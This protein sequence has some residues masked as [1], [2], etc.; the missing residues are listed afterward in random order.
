MDMN[1]DNPTDFSG[2]GNSIAD[3]IHTGVADLQK[4]ANVGEGAVEGVGKAASATVSGAGHL[5]G[6]AVSG[7]AHLAGGATEVAGHATGGLLSGLGHATSWIGGHLGDNS[8]AHAISGAGSSMA[9]SGQSIKQSSD[10]A[11]ANMAAAG[12]KTGANISG[13]A[14]ATAGAIKG[15]AD[16]VALAIQGAVDKLGGVEK[17]WRGR[18]HTAKTLYQWLYAHGPLD[19]LQAALRPIPK[20]GP[21]A[22]NGVHS[23]QQEMHRMINGMLGTAWNATLDAG[24]NALNKVIG[25]VREKTNIQTKKTPAGGKGPI[26]KIEQFAANKFGNVSDLYDQSTGMPKVN[27]ETGT[28]NGIAPGSYTPPSHTEVA[29]D[30]G[31]IENTGAKDVTKGEADAKEEQGNWLS[32]I[33]QQIALYATE[34]VGVPVEACWNVVDGG[35]TISEKDPRLDAIDAK[36]NEFFAHPADC[37][38]WR[39][40]LRG[41]VG[42]MQLGPALLEHLR[43]ARASAPQ[44]P[45]HVP[46]I[47]PNHPANQ[48]DKQDAPAPVMTATGGVPPQ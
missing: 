3:L 2:L 22:A 30:H 45:S 33:A 15:K 11:G 42:S 43:S 46:T 13:S 37:Q 21:A 41:A 40:I 28:M 25:K 8:V 17:E 19:E 32:P 27:P 24:V 36:V 10:Q 31:E 7:A 23:V 1:K 39:P 18:Q 44:E 20:V 5:A 4:L 14:D 6:G 12:D 48:K 16:S 26:H 38:Y 29:K 34:Q 35:G 47:P 9:D